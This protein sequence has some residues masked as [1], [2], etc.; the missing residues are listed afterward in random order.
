[1][2]S[3]PRSDGGDFL[4]PHHRIHQ[5]Q[6]TIAIRKMLYFKQTTC[7]SAR[8]WLLEYYMQTF[9]K[10]AARR[11]ASGLPSCIDS[12]DLEQVGFFGLVEC[13]D[14]FDPTLNYKFETF[15]RRRVE[16]SMLDHLRRIDPA[17]RL[18]R[19]RTKVIARGVNTFY[20]EHG[21]KPTDTE[22]RRLLQFDDKE[23]AAIMRDVHVP[24]TLSLHPADD[25][26][27][28]GLVAVSIELKTSELEKIDRRDL[29][30]WLCETLGTYDKLIILLTYT[31]GL[32]MLE[33]GH[34][35]GYS[36]SRVSQRLK[37]IHAVLKSKLG[38]SDMQLLMAS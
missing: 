4:P 38:D 35:I 30:R 17:S 22:L 27:G 6:A 9:V 28:D 15:A 32:T 3:H 14:K 29:H 2:V 13:I 11:I 37:H 24:N 31:E 7:L 25:D 23:F 33:I 8:N 19:S 36:E 20:A 12:D 10:H 1:M 5:S 16:G 21:R 34:T 18:A 26:D